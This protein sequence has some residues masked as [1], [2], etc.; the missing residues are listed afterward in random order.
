MKLNIEG[1]MK[2][3]VDEQDET[4]T[5][6]INRIVSYCRRYVPNLSSAR[7]NQILYYADRGKDS[8]KFT[9]SQRNEEFLR[10]FPTWRSIF[11]DRLRMFILADFAYGLKNQRTTSYNEWVKNIISKKIDLDSINEQCEIEY[12][13]ADGIEDFTRRVL[14]TRK[15]LT[16]RKTIHDLRTNVFPAHHFLSNE[17]VQPLNFAPILRYLNLN[18]PG[19]GFISPTQHDEFEVNNFIHYVMREK[20][21]NSGIFCSYSSDDGGVL[22]PYPEYIAP[23][24]TSTGEPSIIWG[25]LEFYTFQGHIV[26][27]MWAEDPT[28]ITRKDFFS[29][30]NVEFRRAVAERLGPDLFVKLLDLEVVDEGKYGKLLQTKEVD[31][32]ARRRLNFVQVECPSTGRQYHLGVDISD[33]PWG[34]RRDADAAIAWTFG[35]TKE[36]Y[37]PVVET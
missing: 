3:W 31:N 20:T 17:R 4:P 37:Q 11:A 25:D 35:M 26:P 32:I 9:L 36:E 34:E 30:S 6:Y 27:K 18:I 12:I 5:E 21:A 8:I 29:I 19:F 7:K 15:R 22:L 33:L 28:T 23:T 1:W 24:M 16:R 13:I 2:E 14:N 10:R